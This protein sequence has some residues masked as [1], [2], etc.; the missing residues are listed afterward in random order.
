[1]L[2]LILWSLWSGSLALEILLFNY[3]LNG[4]Q[5]AL[6]QRLCEEEE[7]LTPYESTQSLPGQTSSQTEGSIAKQIEWEYKIVRANR[8]LFR[9]PAIFQRLCQ[10]E[11]EVGWILLEKLD[12]RRVRFKRPVSCREKP[13]QKLPR[14]DPYRC[15]YNT[16]Y[17]WT[18]YLIMAAFLIAVLIPAYLTYMFVFQRLNQR[19]HQAPSLPSLLESSPSNEEG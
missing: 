16:P 11:A 1:M 13:H 17:N 9:N 7:I 4:N 18:F 10:E 8:D 5:T 14:F 2:E 3:L 6:E 15:A 12:D 19:I